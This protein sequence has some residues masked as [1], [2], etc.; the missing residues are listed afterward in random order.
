[1][2]ARALVAVDRLVWTEDGQDLIEYAMLVVLIAVAAVVAV[3]SLGTTIYN[4][5]W[6]TIAGQSF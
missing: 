2:F 1:M 4:V 6:Q 5:F 3:G